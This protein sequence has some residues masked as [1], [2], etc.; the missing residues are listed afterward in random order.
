MTQHEQ[1]RI[2]IAKS[3]RN[4]DDMSNFMIIRGLLW[5]NRTFISVLV[6]AAFAAYFITHNF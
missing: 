3:K 5:R 2:K 6:N 4:F 1:D